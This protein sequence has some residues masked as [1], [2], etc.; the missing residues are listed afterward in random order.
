MQYRNYGKTGYKVSS[1]GMGCMRLPRINL[2]N[3]EAVVDREKAREMIRYA[4]DHGINY[5]DT[6]YGYHNKTSEEVLGEALEG[7]LREKVKIATKQSF[8]TMS[9]LSSG[10]GKTIQ[11]NMRRNLESTLKKLKSSYIDLYLIHGINASVW[12]AIK[13]NKIFD[14]Y[15]K[16]RSEGLI[17]G[18]AFSYHGKFPCFKEVLEYYDWSMCQI[19]QNFLEVD[20]ECTEEAIRIAG[21]KGCALV[22]MEPLR[23]G[24]LST[25]PKRIE[26]I[27]NEYPVK[28]SA[29]EWAFRH[30]IDYPEVSCVLSGMS[31]MEQLKENIEIFSKADAVPGCITQAERQIINRAKLSY[32]SARTIPCTGCEYCLPCPQNVNISRI[33]TRYNDGNMFEN[34]SQIARTYSMLVS[35]K[36]DASQCTECGECEKKCPQHIEISKQLKTVHE[37]AMK[38][39][40]A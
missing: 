5:F 40:Q 26:A 21:K 11:E 36:K 33:F 3:G 15:E 35:Q 23:G 18:I 17:R 32:E 2:E 7:G 38:L 8:N 6:A 20:K 14:E 19:Q 4:V 30:V 9:D 37:A 10:G 22:V 39:Q 28:R 29:V 31:T 27:Y 24:S 13:Q 12:D 25:A 1:L 16:F 34:F